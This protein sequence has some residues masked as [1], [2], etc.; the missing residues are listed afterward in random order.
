MSNL[1]SYGH[2]LKDGAA[3]ERAR[4][5]ALIESRICANCG[6]WP[7]GLSCVCESWRPADLIQIIETNNEREKSVSTK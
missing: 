1:T 2:G 5:I 6:Q 4:I 3:Q 7:E